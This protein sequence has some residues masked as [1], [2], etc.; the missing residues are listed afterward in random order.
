[1]FRRQ[2]Y[3]GFYCG[4]G[5]FS[6]K[7]RLSVWLVRNKAPETEVTAA[8]YFALGGNPGFR[9][10]NWIFPEAC[11]SSNRFESLV[12]QLTPA[13]SFW[14]KRNSFGVDKPLCKMLTTGYWISE[15]D[16]AVFTDLALFAPVPKKFVKR[17]WNWFNN[18]RFSCFMNT[19]Y[20]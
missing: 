2:L 6:N 8:R 13:C 14:N 17:Q 5:M 12:V 1:M 19:K 9:L 10:L 20:K 3:S 16:I 15:K 4:I 18:S 11:F 7:F